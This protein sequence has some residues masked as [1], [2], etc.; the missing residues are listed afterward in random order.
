MIIELPIENIYTELICPI[1]KSKFK[2][3]ENQGEY[4]RKQWISIDNRSVP[5]N[6]V[7]TEI[8]SI[9]ETPHYRL[10][11]GDEEPYRRYMNKNKWKNY[12]IQ[13]SYENFKKLINNFHSYL[14]KP[15]EK[16]YIYCRSDNGKYIV[17]DG[18]HRIS[19]VKF[20]YPNLKN[21]W[22]SI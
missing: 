9:E 14:E 1:D 19:I 16:D 21:I 7:K 11:T 12:G 18:L 13:H 2:L 22:V 4:P 5:H 8:V 20:R 3:L 10:L 15:Y 17:V 6:L